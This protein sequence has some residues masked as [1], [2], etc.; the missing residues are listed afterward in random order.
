MGLF[1]RQGKNTAGAICFFGLMKAMDINGGSTGEGLKLMEQYNII[2]DCSLLL[3][4]GVPC[5]PAISH[6][7]LPNT[8][9]LAGPYAVNCVITPVSQPINPVKTKLYWTRSTSFDSIVMTNTSGNNWTA[10]I[11][12]NGSPATYK[13][14]MKTI[15][16]MNRIGILPGGAPAN[17]FSFTAS[18]DIEKPVITHTA[19]GNTPKVAWPATVTCTVTD[20]IGVDSSWVT[21]K[22]NYSGITKRFK[23]INTSG[24]TYAGAFNSVQA[25]VNYG[26]TIYYRIVAQDISSNHNRD[27]TALYNFAIIAQ[28]N[29][30]I[31]N[32]TIAMG[33]ASGPFNTY[34]YGNRTQ[35]L[36]T[37]AEILSN[38]GGPGIITKIG[39]Q[40]SAVGGQAMS[41]F[42]INM[43]NTALSTL[44]GFTSTGWTNVYSGTYTVPGTGWQ[45]IDLQ[46]PF[47]WNGTSNIMVEVCFGNSSYSTAATVFGTTATGMEYSEYHDISTACTTFNAPTAQT[48]R[49]NTCFTFSLVAGT[50]SNINSV[51]T[52]YSLSQNY[53]NPFNPVT[54]IN[55]DISKQGLV[56]LKVYDILGREVKTLVNEIKSSGKYSVDFNGM[57]LSSGVYFYRLESNGFTDIKRMLM[58]K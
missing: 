45:Y 44:T 21:W 38:Q 42:N 23:L 35:F 48:A 43:Q 33:S 18:T 20:N 39:F 29:C 28:S 2:G 46:T 24:T 41:G 7:Q 16:T 22:K 8:E 4:R 13:Y 32:G 52:K 57:E 9:S 47:A 49:A 55:F 53:P 54:R 50:N 58:I 12:G 6:N 25:D 11:P 17:Y 30:C 40:I 56:M 27:S 14:Y 5:V 31:G 34:W 19:I 37:A 51:P 10:S 1:A 3:T 15:D 36:Y 26:D